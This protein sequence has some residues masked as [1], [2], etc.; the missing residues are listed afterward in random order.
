MT[1]VSVLC[2]NRLYTVTS[3]LCL[4]H[5][6]TFD[7]AVVRGVWYFNLMFLLLLFKLFS[8]VM[9]MEM[10]MGKRRERLVTTLHDGSTY[11]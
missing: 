9:Q 6:E 3:L 7:C 11:F 10:V 8:Q 4:T 2:K 5:Y 1:I